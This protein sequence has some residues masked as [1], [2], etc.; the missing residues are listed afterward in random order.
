MALADVYDALVSKRVYKPPFPHTKAVAI[1]KEG[2][3]THFDPELVDCFL[4]LVDAFRQIA[5][6][7]ADSDGKRQILTTSSGTKKAT[8]HI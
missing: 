2:R 1:I 3:G 7:F 6:R 5:I 8:E 4:D